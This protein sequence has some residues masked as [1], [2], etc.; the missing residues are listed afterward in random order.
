MIA[1]ADT[2]RLSPNQ[3]RVGGTIAITDELKAEASP[4]TV[5]F[6]FAIGGSEDSRVPLAA[7]RATVAELPLA[8]ELDDSMAMIPAMRLSNVSEVVLT[9]R[10]S[11]SGDAI[12]ASGDLQG[13]LEGVKVGTL[14]NQL[15]IDTIIP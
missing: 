6:I 11:H 15:L 14:D 10:V 2:A 12:A 13:V 7:M 9:A 1:N 3:A 8:F 4:E 5:I